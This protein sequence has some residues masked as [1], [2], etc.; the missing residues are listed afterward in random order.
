[1]FNVKRVVLGVCALVASVNA[2]FF[3]F[4]FTGIVDQSNY[5]GVQSGDEFSYSFNINFD[6][7]AFYYNVPLGLKGYYT[8][9]VSE[10]ITTEDFYYSNFVGH[11]LIPDLLSDIDTGY[12]YSVGLSTLNGNNMLF[13]GFDYRMGDGFRIVTVQEDNPISS[14]QVNKTMS[15]LEYFY[16][17]RFTLYE[18]ASTLTLSKI[19]QISDPASPASV[20]EPGTL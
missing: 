15:G 14:W 7:Q 3:E 4:S 6:Q 1:M 10:G 16:D 8:D 19:T 20:P 5:S 2:D 9:V 13:C 17:G 11:Y 12:T 18:I